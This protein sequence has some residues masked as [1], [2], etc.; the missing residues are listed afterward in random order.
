MHLFRSE[1][2]ATH[3]G[4]E[5]VIGI[6]SLMHH[7][8]RRT[9]AGEGLLQHQLCF[10]DPIDSFCYRIIIRTAT[11]G[12]TDGNMMVLQCLNVSITTVLDSSVG[13]MN[14]RSLLLS[15]LQ[16]GNGFIQSNEAALCF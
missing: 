3:M 8:H 11:L 10:Q 5:A 2:A 15:T 9:V 4:S 7:R 6:N 16:G 14:E 12:H 13:V 1:I